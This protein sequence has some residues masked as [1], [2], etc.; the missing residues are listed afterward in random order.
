MGTEKD[1]KRNRRRRRR[2]KLHKLKARLEETKDPKDR[3]RLID[4]I[5]RIS[6]YPPSDLPKK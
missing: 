3:Q 4:K 6:V 2:R 1:R 5:H